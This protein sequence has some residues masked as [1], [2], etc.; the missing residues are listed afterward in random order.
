MRAAKDTL[1][2]AQDEADLGRTGAEMFYRFS[3]SAL[4]ASSQF[5]VVLSGGNTPRNLYK[6]LAT[7]RFKRD[8]PWEKVH[9]F[10]GDE[11]NV[12]P[13]SPDSNF[14]MAFETMLDPLSISKENIHRFRTELE[15]PK[16]VA[17]DYE[18]EIRSYFGLRDRSEKPHFDLV[19]LGLGADGHTASLFPDGKP[20]ISIRKE[21][22]EC[23][24]IAP[25]VPSLGEF[26]FSLTPAALNS[27][28]EVI[29]LVSGREKPDI[30]AKVISLR[31]REGEGSASEETYPVQAICPA[32]GGLVWLVE[33]QAATRLK[34]ERN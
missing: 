28:D 9:F 26:R 24:V 34:N 32:R 13:E 11:R 3:S 33:S 18:N 1:T 12:S 7:G 19:L 21:D 27:S 25:W 6:T 29:F 2:I 14:H 20:G 22:P 4:K 30:L 17:E 16:R 31:D 10:W 15:N 8:I 5:S 23:L